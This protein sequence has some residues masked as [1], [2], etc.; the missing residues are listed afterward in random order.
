MWSFRYIFLDFGQISALPAICGRCGQPRRGGGGGGGGQPTQPWPARF[1]A[2]PP[3]TIYFRIAPSATC[4]PTLM[5]TA[6][7]QQLQNVDQRQAKSAESQQLNPSIL[8]QLGT[9]AGVVKIIEVSNNQLQ[10][11]RHNLPHRPLHVGPIVNGTVYHVHIDDVILDKSNLGI[12]CHMLN[13]PSQ[14]EGNPRFVGT[15]NIIPTLDEATTALATATNKRAKT[16]I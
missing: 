5:T 7:M 11:A 6:N 1:G 15:D 9:R 10:Q 16:K 14:P 4:A 3:T 13:F 8:M 2:P 12:R